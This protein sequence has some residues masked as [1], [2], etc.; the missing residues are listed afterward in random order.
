MKAIVTQYNGTL[1][2][3]KLE[4]QWARTFDYFGISWIYEP[5][6]YRFGNGIMYLPDFYL[7][8]SNQ[9][10]EVKGIMQ[11]L[12]RLKIETLMKEA[13]KDVVVGNADGTFE[14]WDSQGNDEHWKPSD[15]ALCKCKT[16]GKYWFMNSVLTWNCR[17]CGEYEGDHHIERW[18]NGDEFSH[19]FAH[20]QIR[21]GKRSQ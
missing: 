16:C 14:I 11:D 9:F 4:A 8:D 18:Y 17:C 3:S 10:F 1:F 20:M 12:D 6:G 13:H 15:S 5:E 21:V 7:N 19:I 2:R